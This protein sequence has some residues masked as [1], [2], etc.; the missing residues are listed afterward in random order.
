MH[1]KH[2]ARSLQDSVTLLVL[3]S[4]QGHAYLSAT[5]ARSIT[6]D[7]GEITT[8]INI[9]VKSLWWVA[10]VQNHRVV[11]A[12]CKKIRYYCTSKKSLKVKLQT[13]NLNYKQFNI[14]LFSKKIKTP[15]IELIYEKGVKST[16]PGEGEIISRNA[17]ETTRDYKRVV[18]VVPRRI[19]AV[20][21]SRENVIWKV[22]RIVQKQQ[23]IPQTGERTRPGCRSQLSK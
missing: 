8:S 18:P 7:P 4:I 23:H 16:F 1:I 21:L 17:K 15:D 22:K 10:Y 13:W 11:P 14:D 2:N 19:Q 9:Q 20:E 12:N 5:F 3:S 6:L